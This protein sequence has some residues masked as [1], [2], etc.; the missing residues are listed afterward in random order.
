M[1]AKNPVTAAILGGMDPRHALSS[2]LNALPTNANGVPFDTSHV[3]ASGNI[4][5]DM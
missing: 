2:G 4:A 1:G 3:Y 5:A